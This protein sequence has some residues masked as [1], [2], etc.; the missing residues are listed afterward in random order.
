MYSIVDSTLSLDDTFFTVN[1]TQGNVDSDAIVMEPVEQP[2]IED[3]IAKNMAFK[4]QPIVEIEE[5]LVNDQA[6]IAKPRACGSSN[7]IVKKSLVPVQK[8]M[9]K[10]IK[11][12]RKNIIILLAL[13]MILL[14]ALMLVLRM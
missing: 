13:L 4:E 11:S 2:L 8:V 12:A 10:T 5:D 7:R 3:E 6:V 14:L 1:F 9:N